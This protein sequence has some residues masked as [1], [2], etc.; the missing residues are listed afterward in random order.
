[1]HAGIGCFPT[2][3][4][5]RWTSSTAWLSLTTPISDATTSARGS[6]GD[7]AVVAGAKALPVASGA[8]R[9]RSSSAATGKGPASSPVQI[10]P[11]SPPSTKCLPIP[12]RRPPHS[13]LELTRIRGRLTRPNLGAEVAHA[14]EQEGDLDKERRRGEN[15]GRACLCTLSSAGIRAR[16]CR[17]TAEPTT[18]W[19]DP[20]R[21]IQSA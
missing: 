16:G 4:P 8:T 5:W 3:T 11:A 18:F 17:M 20:D 21:P 12:S 9:C 13:S 15:A 7:A 19:H 1:M 10:S 14:I 2:S 6:Q